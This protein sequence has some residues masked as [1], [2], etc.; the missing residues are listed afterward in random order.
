MVGAGAVVTSAVPAFA[1]VVGVPA[2][3]HGWVCRCGDRLAFEAGAATCPG[4]GDRYEQNGQ[5][6]ALVEEE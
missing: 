3:V 5:T 1:L 2:R 6:V 4:C